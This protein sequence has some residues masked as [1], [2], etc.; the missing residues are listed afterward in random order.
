MYSLN[1]QTAVGALK[2]TVSVKVMHVIMI[3]GDLNCVWYKEQVMHFAKC[4]D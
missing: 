4:T 1:M 3:Q 2:K